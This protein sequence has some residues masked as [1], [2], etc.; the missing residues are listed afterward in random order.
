MEEPEERG[1]D[2]HV[3]KEGL[4]VYGVLAICARASILPAFL[5]DSLPAAP[6]AILQ[7]LEK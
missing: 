7:E 1:V 2:R 3:I 5:T 6:Q 4:A